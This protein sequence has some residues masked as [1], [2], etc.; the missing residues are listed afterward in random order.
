MS[1]KQENNRSPG[2]IKKSKAV[3]ATRITGDLFSVRI[4]NKSIDP[5]LI[6]EKIKDFRKSEINNAP[7]DILDM[8]SKKLITDLGREI[9][10]LSDIN[11]LEEGGY[12]LDHPGVK[13]KKN[14][15]KKLNNSENKGLAE[16]LSDY[17]ALLRDLKV[18]MLELGASRELVFTSSFA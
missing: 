7:Y 2:E 16:T 5:L 11:P 6:P 17:E 14:L 12:G 4:N 8:K 15:K 13:A 9:S 18:V 10:S 1:S 3:I